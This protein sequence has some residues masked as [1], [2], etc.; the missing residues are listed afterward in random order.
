ML[1]TNAYQNASRS[2]C[3]ERTNSSSILELHRPCDTALEQEHVEVLMAADRSNSRPLGVRITGAGLRQDVRRLLAHN[4]SIF[5]S[6]AA[7][8]ED[9]ATLQCSRC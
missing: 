3:Q 2:P 9:S 6:K 8:V 1:C 4:A 5:D 7:V